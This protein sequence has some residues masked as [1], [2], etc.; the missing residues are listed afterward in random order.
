[1]I[2][3]Q[4]LDPALGGVDE[5]VR[6]EVVGPFGA[7]GRAG[8]QLQETLGIGDHE[9]LGAELAPVLVGG[10]RLSGG[11]A[12]RREEERGEEDEQPGG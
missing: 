4:E 10:D 1:M 12:G 3:E 5:T 7:R 8:A 2:G 9:V 6:E 11:G